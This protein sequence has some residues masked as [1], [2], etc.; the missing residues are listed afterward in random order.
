MFLFI[1]LYLKGSKFS[2]HSNIVNLGALQTD[3]VEVY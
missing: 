2:D 3:T 1:L